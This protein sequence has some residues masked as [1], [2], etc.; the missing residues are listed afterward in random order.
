MGSSHV[1]LGSVHPTVKQIKFETTLHGH[2]FAR[3]APDGRITLG[4]PSDEGILETVD[5][6]SE[7][8]LVA[9]QGIEEAAGVAASAVVDVAYS[10]Q[11]G[12]ASCRERGS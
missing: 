8:Y 6:A 3:R 5:P 11:I 1:L 4:F 12:R 10:S 7:R 9:V 2:L